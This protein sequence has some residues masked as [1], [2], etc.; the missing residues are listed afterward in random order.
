MGECVAQMADWD[1][2]QHGFAPKKAR[3]WIEVKPF[4]PND[5]LAN[6]AQI[7]W[8]A[9]LHVRTFDGQR[10]TMPVIPDEHNS[11]PDKIVRPDDKPYVFHRMADADACANSELPGF[12][13]Y[14][15]SKL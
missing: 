12:V 13:S 15:E 5:Q 14:I 7:D 10:F 9:Y 4:D 1:N 8:V 2:E 3:G 6:A 11:R